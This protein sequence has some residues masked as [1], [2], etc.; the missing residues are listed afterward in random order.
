MNLIKEKL[1]NQQEANQSHSIPF[2]RAN[3]TGFG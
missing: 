3:T 2:Y 1:A